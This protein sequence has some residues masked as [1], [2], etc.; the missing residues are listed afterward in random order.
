MQPCCTHGGVVSYLSVYSFDGEIRR[1]ILDLKYRNQRAIANELAQ[2]LVRYAHRMVDVS[3][4]HVVTWPPTSE[5]R[6]RQRGI[7]HS[8]LLA[9]HVGAYIGVPTR[10]MLRKVNKDPQTGAPR[11]QRL[12]QVHFVASV[13][14]W[15]RAV[16]VIDD[17]ITTGATM[18]AASQA[19][20]EEGVDEVLCLAVASTLKHPSGDQR[21]QGSK[22]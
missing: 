13:P 20:C 6:R 1:K 16:I 18:A 5:H 22:R 10:R 4:Y 14:R 3:C 12:V 7:D 15:A 9:R 11:T 8:E 17:V 2:D 19:L 21:A